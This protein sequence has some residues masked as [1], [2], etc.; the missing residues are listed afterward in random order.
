MIFD[1]QSDFND[2]IRYYL[3]YLDKRLYMVFFGLKEGVMGNEEKKWLF[4]REN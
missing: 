3:H 1:V 2:V 4:D